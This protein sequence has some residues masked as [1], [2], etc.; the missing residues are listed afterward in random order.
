MFRCIIT[1]YSLVKKSVLFLCHAV[2]RL[3]SSKEESQLRYSTVI[4]YSK[5][6]GRVADP[7]LYSRINLVLPDPDKQKITD[8]DPGLMKI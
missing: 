2:R 8:M 5:N 7:D 1:Y 3:R 6:R 4:L